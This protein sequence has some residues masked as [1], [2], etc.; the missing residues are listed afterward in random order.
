[1]RYSLYLSAALMGAAVGFSGQA[2][3]AGTCRT[4]TLTCATTMPVGG[5]CECTAR[6]NTQ[7]GEVVGS[8][9]ATRGAYRQQTHATAGGCGARPNDPGC[10]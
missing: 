3:A 2:L 7:S 6:G 8:A 5:Y 9:R 10:S 4:E 1:M